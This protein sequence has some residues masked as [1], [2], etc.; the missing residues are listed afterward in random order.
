MTEYYNDPNPALTDTLINMAERIVQK[1]FP[2]DLEN[3]DKIVTYFSKVNR[4]LAEQAS[5]MMDQLI[6]IGKKKS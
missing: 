5:S 6:Q 4:F 3:K 1:E 2:L